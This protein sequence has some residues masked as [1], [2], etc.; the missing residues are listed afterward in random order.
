[1]LLPLLERT[2]EQNAHFLLTPK[3]GARIGG[4]PQCG[5]PFAH[6]AAIPQRALLPGEQ[7]RFHFD[8]TNVLVASVVLWLATSRTAIPRISTGGE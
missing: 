2:K 6:E 3:T 5:T 7:Y 8:M 4:E 1:M